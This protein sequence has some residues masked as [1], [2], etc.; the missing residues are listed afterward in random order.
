MANVVAEEPAAGEDEVGPA[1][2]D[3]QAV[4]TNVAAASTAT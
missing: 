3:E 4:T 1:V 2:E